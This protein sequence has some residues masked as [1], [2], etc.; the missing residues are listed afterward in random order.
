MLLVNES[1][2]LTLDTKSNAYKRILFIKNEKDLIAGNMPINI[3][4]HI[5]G[6]IHCISLRTVPWCPLWTDN[7]PYHKS[8]LIEK[9]ENKNKIATRS[10]KTPPPQ[11]KVKSTYLT[12]PVKF[13]K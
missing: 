13:A 1:F 6:M 10:H 9:E 2:R 12:T 11:K 5:Q 3:L 7:T 4:S 8:F